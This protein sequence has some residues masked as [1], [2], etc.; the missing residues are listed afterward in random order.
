VKYGEQDQ[1]E[2]L[3]NQCHE[4]KGNG[5]VTDVDGNTI[6]AL[7]TDNFRL[8]QQTCTVLLAIL[9]AW[10]NDPNAGWIKPT[11][12]RSFGSQH[13]VRFIWEISMNSSLLV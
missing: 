1:H 2:W 9:K 3:F 11:D 13:Y 6:V 7:F 4:L 8:E 10:H 5:I 12:R